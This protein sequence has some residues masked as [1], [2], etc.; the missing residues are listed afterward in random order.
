MASRQWQISYLDLRIPS[1][2]L[3]GVQ[4]TQV[5]IHQTY[6]WYGWYT[7]CITGV[8]GTLCASGACALLCHMSKLRCHPSTPV[9]IDQVSHQT[10]YSLTAERSRACYTA[11]M[12]VRSIQII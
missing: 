11:R 2:Q 8:T 10:Y 9:H 5:H 3:Q 6:N 1:Q 7:T 12:V 4:G